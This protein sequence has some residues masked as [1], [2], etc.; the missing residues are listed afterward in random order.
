MKPKSD[1]WSIVKNK[2]CEKIKEIADTSKKISTDG[3]VIRKRYINKIYEN[4]ER[5]ENAVGI[6]L[7]VKK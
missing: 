3:I 5:E 6:K 1:I 7:K 2:F 4:R